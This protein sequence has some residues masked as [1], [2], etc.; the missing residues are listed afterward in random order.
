[1]SESQRRKV[2]TWRLVA[3]FLAPTVLVLVAWIWSFVAWKTLPDVS[4]GTLDEQTRML[5]LATELPHTLVGGTALLVGLAAAVYLVV[6]RQW[7]LAVA[8]VICQ[9]PVQ[10]AVF[11]ATIAYI[12][13]KPPGW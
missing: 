12:N 11:L 10:A 6:R 9:L 4:S 1:M 3:I 7:W 8:A 13:F 2:S 5:Y